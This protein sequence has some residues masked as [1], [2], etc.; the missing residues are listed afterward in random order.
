MTKEVLLIEQI[1][2]LGIEGD[3]V[4]VSNGYARNFLLPNG[5]ASEVTEGLRRKVEKKRALRIEQLKKDKVVAEDL[6][7]KIENI[8]VEISVKIGENNKMFGSVGIPQI[9]NELKVKQIEVEKNKVKLHAPI[10][11]LG[12]HEVV[13]K[14]HPEVETTLKVKVIAEK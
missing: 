1:E 13:L 5:Y 14:L 11:E 6:S 4:K 8:T 2:G 3:I 10:S 9:I 12:D 7:Q